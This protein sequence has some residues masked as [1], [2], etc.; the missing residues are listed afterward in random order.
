MYVDCWLRILMMIGRV[1]NLGPQQCVDL[2][3]NIS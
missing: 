2:G 3:I 1:L